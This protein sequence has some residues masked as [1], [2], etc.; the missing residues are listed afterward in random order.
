MNAPYE[1]AR[2]REQLA[3]ALRALDDEDE[4]DLELDTARA[5]FVRLGAR[6]DAEA[7]EA[8]DQGRRRASRRPSH[9]GRTF[10]FT[11][12]VGSTSLAETIGDA[13]WEQLLQRHDDVIR[14]PGQADRGNGR[15]LDR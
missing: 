12:I 4:A 9:A 3:V 2:V 11:D 7:A 14:E 13:A 15:Q 6:L 5:E 8:D 10:M 1:V